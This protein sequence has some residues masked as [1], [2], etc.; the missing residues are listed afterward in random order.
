MAAP[1]NLQ[2][3]A[4]TLSEQL[5]ACEQGFFAR[6]VAQGYA[7]GTLHRKKLALHSF[8]KWAKKKRFGFC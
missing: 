5:E 1:S 4:I 2:A 3:P 6:L 7:S 8:F